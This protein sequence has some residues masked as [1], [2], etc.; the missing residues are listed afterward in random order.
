MLF[1]SGIGERTIELLAVQGYETVEQISEED[2]DR[3]AIR[4]GLGLKKARTII[5]GA[6][7]FL[8]SEK[9]I[10]EEAAAIAEQ[11]QAGVG[12]AVEEAAEGAGGGEDGDDAGEAVEGAG[13]GEDGDD[14]GEAVEGAG[15]GEDDEDDEDDGWGDVSRVLEESKGNEKQ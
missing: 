1:V 10:L 8:D 2:V 14:A 5:Q 12:P 9:A 13:G 15:G 6:R 11:A 3:F 4:T 7:Q